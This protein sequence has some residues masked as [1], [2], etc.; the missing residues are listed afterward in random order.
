M[1]R[2]YPFVGGPYDGRELMVPGPTPTGV[3]LRVYPV[4]PWVPGESYLLDERG[5]FRY[6]SAGKGKRPR[7]LAPPLRI[8]LKGAIR[9]FLEFPSDHE[10]PGC[11]PGSAQAPQNP[12]RG[13]GSFWAALKDCARWLN[14]LG[15]R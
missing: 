7:P 4:E 6:A 12:S 15:R 5:Y 9:A 13:S 8:E 3:E 10:W 2:L 11:T 14:L 1:E